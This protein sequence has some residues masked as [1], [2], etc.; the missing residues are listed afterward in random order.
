[1]CTRCGGVAVAD[2][3]QMTLKFPALYAVRQQH[4][5]LMSASTDTVHFLHNITCKFSCVSLF[6]AVLMS[7][8]M[9]CV[10]FP[11]ATFL[12]LQ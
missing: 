1:M 9:S 8:D 12:L 2:E 7:S 11:V 6:Y 10:V 5:P 4:A 3:M